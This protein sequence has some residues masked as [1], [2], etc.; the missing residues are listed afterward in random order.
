MHIFDKS[1]RLFSFRCSVWMKSLAGL[2]ILVCCGQVNAEV[3]SATKQ[4]IDLLTPITVLEGRFDQ[5]LTDAEGEARQ[6]SQGEFTVKRP[7][8]FRWHTSPPYE[9]LLISN[10]ATLWL[11]DPDLEQ[12]TV[13]PYDQR[14]QQT[15]AIL[16]S[17]EANKIGN[18]FR[19]EKI[20]LPAADKPESSPV[21]IEAFALYPKLA[22]NLFE[23]LTMSFRA[24]KPQEIAI[25]DSLGQKTAIT[26]HELHINKAV[27]DSLFEFVPPAGTD[28]LVDE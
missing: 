20:S 6:L 15:P 25:Y 19:I 12:V 17:G 27:E 18:H 26:F 22:D 11:Y 7:G 8:K 5:Q 21:S 9:Q 10:Q 2:I 4:L 3:A 1:L 16:L 14:L 13:R 24:G 23:K 28:I